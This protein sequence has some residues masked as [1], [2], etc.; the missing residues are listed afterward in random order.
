MNVKAM[1]IAGFLSIVVETGVVNVPESGASE[2]KGVGSAARIGHGGSIYG[3]SLL[4][5]AME[6]NSRGK[7][8]RNVD[9]IERIGHGGSTYSFSR[10]PSIQPAGCNGERSRAD[11][12][13]RI[14]HGGSIYTSIQVMSD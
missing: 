12:A 4:D 5:G 8:R 14:G 6:C 11:I 9:I 10:P 13:K 1:L 7:E 2:P 3:S